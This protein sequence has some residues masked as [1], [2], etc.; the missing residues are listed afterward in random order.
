MSKLPF[1]QYSGAGNTFLL[2]DDRE[3]GFPGSDKGF[4]A[5]ICEERKADGVLL[6][7]DEGKAFRMRILNR[8]GSEAESCGNGLR[9][10]LLFLKEQ[11]LFQKRVRIRT[12]G[13]VVE[14]FFQ[15]GE[16]AL[17]MGE[18]KAL[19]QVKTEW[20]TLHLLDTGVPHG[21]LFVSDLKELDFEGVGSLLRRRFNANIDF[22][23]KEGT[24]IQARTFERGVEGETLSCGTGA[25]AVGALIK[26]F[27]DQNPV[28]IEFPG[29]VLRVFEK[30]KRL[31][32]SGPAEKTFTGSLDFPIIKPIQGKIT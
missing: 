26:R 20:G 27:F 16:P 32:L 24:R 18:P 19:S 13:A 2:F 31:I 1:S 5:K 8:D 11:G 12:G 25:A 23:K 9:C 15:D 17:D 3:K 4:I 7:S 21:V 28:L 10:T 14:G 6:I 22:V 30:E 29:G